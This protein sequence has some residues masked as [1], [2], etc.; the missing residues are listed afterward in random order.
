MNRLSRDYNY[1]QD[2]GRGGL[3]EEFA[4]AIISIRAKRTAENSH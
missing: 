3:L 4:A 1:D 2:A